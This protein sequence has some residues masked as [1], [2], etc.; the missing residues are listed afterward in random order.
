MLKKFILS[1]A[2]FTAAATALPATADAGSRHR[3]HHGYS[4]YYDDDG[5][6]YRGNR[7]GYYNRGYYGRSSDYGYY[8]RN[9]YGRRHYRRCGS[10]TTGAIVG[11]AAGALLGREIARGSGRGYYHRGGNGTTG[12]IIGGAAGALLGRE[13][14]RNC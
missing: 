11:G 10:G 1:I 4:Q 8:D 7:R 9:Y 5:Y 13:I 6:R 12:L 3:R 14:G 2:A